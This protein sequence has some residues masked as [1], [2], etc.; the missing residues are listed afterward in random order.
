[1]A[2]DYYKLLG[3]ARDATKDEIK[4]AYQARRAEVQG[5]GSAGGATLGQLNEAWQTLA[6]PYQRGRY[7]ATL[8][9]TDDGVPPDQVEIA[10]DAPPPPRRRG[11]FQPTERA[12]A[13]PPL[14]PTI[15]I[16]E[17]MRL[18]DQRMRLNAMMFDL[19]IIILLFLGVNF[20]GQRFIESRY[21][22]QVDRLEVLGDQFEG[23]DAV[24]DAVDNRADVEDD[25]AQAREAGEPTADLEASLDD[26]RAEVAQATGAP[27][28]DDPDDTAADYRAA[29]TTCAERNAAIADVD[30]PDRDDLDACREVLEDEASELLSDLGPAQYG[31]FALGVLVGLAYLVGSSLRSG[32]TL[33]KRLRKIR[34][35]AQDGRRATF[36]MLMTRYGLPAVVTGLTLQVLGFI[37]LALVLVGVLMWMRNPNRQGMHDRAAKTLV[38]EAG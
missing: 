16:P 26:A 24:I 9:A 23:L 28:A 15:P 14:E 33:G 11:L 31:A 34:V 35:V 5:G 6:D 22:D 18:A 32:Q 19:A 38:V 2:D 27:G 8:D 25:L 1:M 29:A 36:G 10:D 3:V 13:R 21:P 4:Q 12:Q 17:G 30:A 7:D 37:G 20:A